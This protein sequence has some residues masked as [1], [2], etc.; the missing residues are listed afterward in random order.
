MLTKLVLPRKHECTVEKALTAL[1]QTNFRIIVADMDC[2]IDM[3]V[4][5]P[6][7]CIITFGWPFQFGLPM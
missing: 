2:S 5:E 7:W 4:Y 6:A 3:M 1:T